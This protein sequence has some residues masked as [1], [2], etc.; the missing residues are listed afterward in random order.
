MNQRRRI[1]LRALP[2]Y[3]WM[4]IF[5]LPDQ[6]ADSVSQGSGPTGGQDLRDATLRALSPLEPF[7]DPWLRRDDGKIKANP[8]GCSIARYVEIRDTNG[9]LIY[10]WRA[11][12]SIQPPP[13]APLPPAVPTPGTPVLDPDDP[14]APATLDRSRAGLIIPGFVGVGLLGLIVSRR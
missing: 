9:S 6:D 12:S 11:P 2:A 14:S 4:T 13:S 10:Q 1:L 8:G 5:R 3:S 7:C